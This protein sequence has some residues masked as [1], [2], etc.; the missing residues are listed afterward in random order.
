MSKSVVDFAVI[1]LK[2]LTA[3]ERVELFSRYCACCGDNVVDCAC[4]NGEGN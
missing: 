2:G 1:V 4:W 3:K